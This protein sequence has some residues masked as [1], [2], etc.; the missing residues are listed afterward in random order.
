MHT[1]IGPILHKLCNSSSRAAGI[2]SR[3]YEKLNQVRSRL[4]D[5][6]YMEHPEGITAEVDAK[7]Y[8]GPA[9]DGYSTPQDSLKAIETVRDLLLKGYGECKPRAQMLAKVE[10]AVADLQKKVTH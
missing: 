10:S 2:T 8:Y 5:W 1:T 3:I 4:E 7:L 9:V 6:A